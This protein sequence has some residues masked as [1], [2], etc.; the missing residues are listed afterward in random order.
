MT[1]IKVIGFDVLPELYAF[2]PYFGAIYSSAQAKK[3]AQYTVHDGF[4]FRRSQLYIPDCSIRELIIMEIHN[5][6]QRGRDKSVEIL[7]RHYF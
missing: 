1:R 3:S 2:D 6:G 5:E 4:L 7:L